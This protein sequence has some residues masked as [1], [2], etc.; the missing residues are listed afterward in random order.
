M[1]GLADVEARIDH[2]AWRLAHGE[3][4]DPE[5]FGALMDDMLV[6]AT[7]LAPA[8]RERLRTRMRRLGEALSAA[9]DRTEDRLQH[10]G[11]GRRAVQGY[12]DATL[13]PSPSRLI[14]AA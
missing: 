9:K 12:T 8:D 10:L 11:P 7:R 2:A 13:G 6:V 5:V 4:L 3:D 1:P 14:R